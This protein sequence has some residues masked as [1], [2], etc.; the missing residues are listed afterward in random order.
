MPKVSVEQ[1][2]CINIDCAGGDVGPTV[3]AG[4]LALTL[5][6]RG[7]LDLGKWEFNFYPGQFGVTE[8]SGGVEVSRNWDA[9]AK[10]IE[11]NGGRYAVSIG[12]GQS[13]AGS[14]HGGGA[15]N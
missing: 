3:F 2:R 5:A 10:T 6:R 13:G 11:R 7:Q 1:E 9:A 8:I 14:I 12:I 4:Q 15:R